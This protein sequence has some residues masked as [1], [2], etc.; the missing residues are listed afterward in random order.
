MVASPHLSVGSSSQYTSLFLRARPKPWPVLRIPGVGRTQAI[1]NRA[2]ISLS[3]VHSELSLW[4]P[5]R[6]CSPT[7][8][9]SLGLRMRHLFSLPWLGRSH[10]SRPVACSPGFQ[11]GNSPTGKVLNVKTVLLPTWLWGL[12]PKREREQS[13]HNT[14]YQK[15]RK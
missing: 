6:S 11:P 7:S 14:L 5:R 15:A 9:R 4:A 8:G 12:V 10:C 1:R 13:K 2:P 3:G